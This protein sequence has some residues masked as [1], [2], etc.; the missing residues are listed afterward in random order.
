MID[1]HLDQLDLPALP[2]G[3]TWRTRE[4]LNNELQAYKPGTHIVLF[5]QRRQRVLGLNFHWRD[6]TYP[7]YV[8]DRAQSAQYL[9][10]TAKLMVSQHDEYVLNHNDRAL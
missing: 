4:F 9:E 7:A 6:E 10:E 2:A 3:R 1:E 5:V 8:I